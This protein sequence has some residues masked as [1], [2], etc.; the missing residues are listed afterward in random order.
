MKPSL[1][2]KKLDCSK[3]W[4]QETTWTEEDE[5]GAPGKAEKREE[6]GREESEWFG[7]E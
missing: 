1:L 6:R 5:E 3:D 7:L 2:P 4:R